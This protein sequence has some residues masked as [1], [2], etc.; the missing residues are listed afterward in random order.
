MV[1]VVVWQL[2][3]VSGLKNFTQAADYLGRQSIKVYPGDT[4]QLDS[5]SIVSK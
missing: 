2:F 4:A 3:P 1:L 5:L